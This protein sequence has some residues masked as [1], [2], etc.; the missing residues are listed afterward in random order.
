MCQVLLI[1]TDQWINLKEFNCEDI[2]FTQCLPDYVPEI[3]EMKFENR[4]YIAGYPDENSCS[5]HFRIRPLSLG[6]SKQEDW[7]YE[8]E[9]SIQATKIAY[10]ILKS[11]M[12]KQIKF[13]II[14]SWTQGSIN[15]DV[16]TIHDI[17]LDFTN[18]DQDKFCFIENS[19]MLYAHNKL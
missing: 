15:T 1:S 10:D 8:N 14:V 7:F 12:D 5:C 13:E 4:W 18:V 9:Q 11:L 3:Y 19:R 16:N 6:F 17:N 2:S